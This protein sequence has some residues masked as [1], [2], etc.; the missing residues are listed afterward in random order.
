MIYTNTDKN[1]KV[2]AKKNRELIKEGDVVTCLSPVEA[3]YSGMY[4]GTPSEYSEQWFKPG[5]IGI[6]RGIN[7]PYVRNPG[8]KY[9]FG[10][11]VSVEFTG[12]NHKEWRVALP[13]NNVVLVPQK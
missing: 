6:V 7:C 11:F 9:P 4:K 3:G 2:S 12:D 8:N 1:M 10:R 5:M 13:Y